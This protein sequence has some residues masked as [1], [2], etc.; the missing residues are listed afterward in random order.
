MT[1]CVHNNM[2]IKEK[3]VIFIDTAVEK[4]DRYLYNISPMW[5]G[6]L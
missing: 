4:K 1:Y 6:S 3:M 2:K 5:M